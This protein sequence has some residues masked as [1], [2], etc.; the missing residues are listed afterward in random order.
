[1]LRPGD[2]LF[3]RYNGNPEF[4]GVAGV[5]RTN[6]ELVYPDKLIRLRLPDGS[7]V[8]SDF[9][10]IAVNS[11]LAR[12]FLRCRV[13]T[14]AGQAGISGADLKA[15][16]V[17]FPPS[18]SQQAEVVQE[19]HRALTEAN[20]TAAAVATNLRRSER[21]RSAILKLAFEGRLVGEEED[22]IHA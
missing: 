1:L 15:C 18:R 13:R 4:V 9:L 12:K 22:I 6:D 2:L 14:T 5:V 16:P 21:L 17:A 7:P 11:G 3:T 20:A 8:S 10:E 19:V